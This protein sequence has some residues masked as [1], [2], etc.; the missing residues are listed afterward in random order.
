MFCV[1]PFWRDLFSPDTH[2]CLVQLVNKYSLFDHLR[3]STNIS[4]TVLFL[5]RVENKI[6]NKTI[7]Y[8][9]LKASFVPVMIVCSRLKTSAILWRQNLHISVVRQHLCCL[10]T[11]IAPVSP[12][13]EH[14]LYSYN[15]FF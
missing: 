5:L 12:L 3:F 13:T 15:F 7:S 11:H 10:P 1:L 9:Q 2:S 8:I 14:K 6:T 4:F